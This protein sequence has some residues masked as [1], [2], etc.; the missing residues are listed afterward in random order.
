VYLAEIF[1]NHS[2]EVYVRC[3]GRW[4]ERVIVKRGGRF[5]TR[6]LKNGKIVEGALA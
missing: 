2:P 3:L 4:E 5:Y 1:L 6:T